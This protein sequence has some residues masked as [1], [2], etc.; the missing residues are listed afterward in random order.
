MNI[1]KIIVDDLGYTGTSVEMNGK[2]ESKSDYYITPNLEQLAKDGVRFSNCYTNAPVCSATRV[3][4][5]TGQAVHEHGVTGLVDFHRDGP[6]SK[7]DLIKTTEDFDHTRLESIILRDSEYKTGFF[8]RWNATGVP[9]DFGYDDAENYINNQNQ[10]GLTTNPKRANEILD[11]AV[12]FL[13]DRAEDGSKFVLTYSSGHVHTRVAWTQEGLDA[14][15]GVP[16]GENHKNIYYAAMHWDMDD[17]IGRLL[18]MVDEL[19]FRENTYIIFTS[20]NGVVPEDKIPFSNANPWRGTKGTLYE[21]GIKV[22]LIIRGPGIKENTIDDTFV[23]S[24]DIYHTVM[25]QVTTHPHV[26]PR[27]DI[28]S[29]AKGFQNQYKF[30]QTFIGYFPHQGR[31]IDG[32]PMACI[33]RNNF[34][35]VIH[36]ETSSMQLFDLVDDPFETTNVASEYPTLCKELY[37]EL[38]DVIKDSDLPLLLLNRGNVLPS[39]SKVRGDSD[40]D[41]LPDWYE[42][43]Y[44]LVHSFGADDDPD[45]DGKTNKE[46]FLDGTDPLNPDE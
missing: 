22:P 35:F 5:F 16:V 40:I 3:S 2:P 45:G 43:K 39:G 4:L 6:D 15:Q 37:V 7:Y 9:Q 23:T 30:D 14:M 12:K 20:D 41:G 13:K 31:N 34:K 44:F 10:W 24:A 26:D 33:R 29:Y 21:G 27:R 18:D 42:A 46:E 25:N 38:R 36:F 32:G 11:G 17:Y 28:I 1:I 19:G 8:G